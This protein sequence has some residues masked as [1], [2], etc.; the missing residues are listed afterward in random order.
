MQG[1]YFAYN[2]QVFSGY[3]P[4]TCAPYTQNVMPTNRTVEKLKKKHKSISGTNFDD[5][6]S[7]STDESI[8]LVRS[9]KTR[10]ESRYDANQMLKKRSQSGTS[11]MK[12]MASQLSVPRSHSDER[13]MSPSL[14]NE[15]RKN[16]RAKNNKKSFSQLEDIDDNFT[17]SEN[18]LIDPGYLIE[19]SANPQHYHQSQYFPQQYNQYSQY[20]QDPYTMQFYQQQQQQQNQPQTGYSSQAPPGA[21]VDYYQQSNTQTQNF[22]P[23]GASQS[24]YQ[25]ADA[26]S[27][28]GT[29]TRTF[30]DQQ[31]QG[32]PS[33]AK[34]V[35]EYFMG[36]LDEQQ[37]YSQQLPQPARQERGECAPMMQYPQYQQYQQPQQPQVQYPQYQSYQASHCPPGCEPQSQCP[38]GCEPQPQKQ[39]LCPSGCEPD[40][41]SSGSDKEEVD[42]EIWEKPS[43]KDKRH[44]HKRSFDDF[45][46][47]TDIIDALEKKIGNINCNGSGNSDPIQP[48]FL[49]PKQAEQAPAKPI[50]IPRNIYVPVIRPVFVP[51][52]RIIV[53]PQ[54]VHVARPVLV[55]RPVPIQQ[56]PLV[57]ERDRP[58]PVRVETIER[59][60]HQDDNG[61][62]CVP[63]ASTTETTYHE[64]IQPQRSSSTGDL[65]SEYTHEENNTNKQLVLDLL[66]E[67]ERRKQSLESKSNESFGDQHQ[68]QASGSA[69]QY[70]TLE[71]MGY[72]SGYTLEVLDQ[73]VSDKFEKV[74]Q[75]TIKQRY[76]VDS[77]QYLPGSEAGGAT[78]RSSG[79]SYK[80][81]TS[82]VENHN[83][84]TYAHSSNGNLSSILTDL[85]KLSSG[86]NK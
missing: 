41:A 20:Q 35:A 10:D 2:N 25:T 82:A 83:E 76:G 72:N 85:V 70:Q 71:S 80:S 38:P 64:F 29:G 1:D 54:I 74:D 15:K 5:Y 30:A 73:R 45:K 56:R 3:T 23:S 11:I 61:E 65:Q 28:S 40:Y 60:E 46:K 32:L 17:Y 52:E 75:E 50:Y 12:G 77:F 59:T 55:D 4:Y 16:R 78:L 31:A 22:N 13:S 8:H 51:R 24:Y 43:K 53:R 86:N 9:R 21:P 34:I 26:Y 42:I 58:V 48:I 79:G 57:I 14:I 62:P 18:R 37:Q 63:K 33:G 44:K 66:A 47:L 81:L 39:P 69:S 84:S 19:Q 49:M 7:N 67:A 6:V 27:G 68:Q 36:Y